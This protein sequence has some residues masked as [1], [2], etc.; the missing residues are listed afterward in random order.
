MQNSA[1]ILNNS[2]NAGKPISGSPMTKSLR[3][4]LPAV[5][6]SQSSASPVK[7]KFGQRT[8]IGRQGNA[9]MGVDYSE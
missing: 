9:G 7:R 6:G 2:A 8:I 3:R 5:G 4:P 1:L